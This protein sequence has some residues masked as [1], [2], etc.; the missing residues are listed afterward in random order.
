MNIPL[1][2]VIIPVYNAEKYIASCVKSILEQSYESLEVILV[3]DGSKDSSL[4]LCREFAKNDE[5]VYVIDQPNAGP[6]AS[7]NRGLAA[8]KGDFVVF[9]DS[10]DAFYSPAT[11]EENIKFFD[12]DT[13]IDIVSFPQYREQKDGY[14]KTKDGQF[15]PQILTDKLTMFTNWYN[16]R[17]IDGHFPGKI[18]RKSLFEGWKLVETIR[19]TEDHYDIPN[20]CRRVGKVKISG[21]GGYTYRCNPQSLIH[22]AYTPENRRGQFYSETNIYRYLCELNASDSAK[23]YFYNMALENAYYLSATKYADETLQ[24]LKE[25]PRINQGGSRLIKALRTLSSLVGFKNGFRI[26]RAAAKLSKLLAA[27]PNP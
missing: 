14:L 22:S 10:D 12:E 8:A 26:I 25:I 20:I 5:R 4:E 13:E 23:A 16:G 19:F 15:I 11:L 17:L 1:I 2:S 21:V 27:K 7:R 3:N 24:I 9:V 18:F 6:N